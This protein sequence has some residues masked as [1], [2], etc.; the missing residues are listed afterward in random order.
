MQYSVSNLQEKTESTD[1]VK[2]TERENSGVRALSLSRIAVG[3]ILSGTKYIQ[4]NDHALPIEEG[5]IFVLDA[6]FHYEE[7]VIGVNGKFEQITFFISPNTLQQAIFGLNINYGLSYVSHHSCSKCLSRNFCSMNAD[8]PLRNFFVGIDLSL[9]SSG[10]LHNDIGQ[11]IKLNELI[12]LLLSSED[13]CV[14]R[15]VLRSS[16]TASGQF[17]NT[18]YENVFNDISIEMLAEAT[19]RSLTSFKKEFRRLFNTPPHRWIIEQ[20]LI[21]ARILLYSTNRTVSEI[22]SECAFSNISHFI[23]LFKQRYGE[24]PATFRRCHSVIKDDDG[25]RVAVGE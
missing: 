1:V 2:I 7:N 5:D 18:I 3:Y 24:T 19:N 13:G 15:K 14:K 23:K 20:R 11:R 21:R 17:I 6:G 4:Y 9:R 12:Y 10:M 16:D 22:G 8:A 25:L